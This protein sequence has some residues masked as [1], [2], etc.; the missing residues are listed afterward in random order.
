MLSLITFFF[1]KGRSPR[2]TQKG[3][4]FARNSLFSLRVI[5]HIPHK[6]TLQS[7]LILAKF[8]FVFNDCLKAV[9]FKIPF[10]SC[11]F[12]KDHWG[13]LEWWWKQAFTES[14]KKLV[15]AAAGVPLGG[16]ARQLF[17][18]QDGEQ[19]LLPPFSHGRRNT[20]RPG[21]KATFSQWQ[22]R[23]NDKVVG[24]RVSTGSITAQLHLGSWE[25]GLPPRSSM[26]LSRGWWPLLCDCP[27]CPSGVADHHHRGWGGV[28]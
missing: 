1:P 14:C 9:A 28:G 21:S 22:T 10:F 26:P 8:C 25:A 12:C 17:P 5:L 18:S 19:A 16:P 20:A 23:N 15:R 6:R 4:K 2:R 3:F 7:E 11:E 13:A 24:T 27:V